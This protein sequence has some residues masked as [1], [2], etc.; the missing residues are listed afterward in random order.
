MDEDV[1]GSG[2]PSAYLLYTHYQALGLADADAFLLSD[3]GVTADAA[4]TNPRS[5]LGFVSAALHHGL[6][7]IDE[8]LL[9][10]GGDPN[11]AWE[12]WAEE[13]TC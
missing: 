12:E 3:A 1:D 2:A 10:A 6:D 9:S 13:E 11:L 4:G 8:R 5:V 7:D